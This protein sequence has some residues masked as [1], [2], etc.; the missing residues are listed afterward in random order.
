MI[1]CGRT[2]VSAAETDSNCRSI[3][4]FVIKLNRACL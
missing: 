3:L 4:S 2:H 1:M